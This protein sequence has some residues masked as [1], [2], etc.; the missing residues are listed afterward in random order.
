[1]TIANLDELKLAFYNLFVEV[2]LDYRQYRCHNP[3]A[4]LSYFFYPPCRWE[5]MLASPRRPGEGEAIDCRNLLLQTQKEAIGIRKIIEAAG[6][7]I[8]TVNSILRLGQNP[9]KEGL[10][11]I[12]IEV[13]LNDGYHQGYTPSGDGEEWVESGNLIAAIRAA[14]FIK[15]GK[16]L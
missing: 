14:I 13:I 5:Q 9:Q 8:D 15:T 2:N 6:V 3:K 12:P 10:T 11:L 7:D 4:I 1:M 16:S